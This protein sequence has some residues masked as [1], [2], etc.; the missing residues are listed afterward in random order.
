MVA[1]VDAGAARRPQTVCLDRIGSSRDPNHWTSVTRL[2]PPSWRSLRE[3]SYESKKIGYSSRPHADR[4][5]SVYER[6]D[7]GM[8]PA[9]V[10]YPVSKMAAAAVKTA[11]LQRT[12]V[13]KQRDQWPEPVATAA[14]RRARQS[15][16]DETPRSAFRAPGRR[17]L[18][19]EPPRWKPRSAG[20][21][22]PA[23]RALPLTASQAALRSCS[24]WFLS[25]GSR[26]GSA[27]VLAGLSCRRSA[28]TA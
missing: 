28:T 26:V 17:S 2:D 4:S 6:S 23:C 3:P 18:R 11:A 15:R 25:V 1:S 12:A 27:A 10:A 13:H 24:S 20:A 16:P 19:S 8:C 21:R 5:T 7:A 14:T 9:V 22:G